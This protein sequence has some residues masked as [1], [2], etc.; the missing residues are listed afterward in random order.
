[1][2][3]IAPY[4]IYQ[5]FDDNGNPLALGKLNTYAAGTITPKA[6]YTD[7]GGLTQNSNPV[8]LDASGMANVWLGDGGYKFVLTDADDNVIFTVDNIGG[9]TDTAFGADVNT[10]TGNTNINTTYANSANIC[11]NSPTLSLLAATSAGEGFYI[12]VKNAGSGIVTIDP[13]GGELIDG[14]A[15]LAIPAGLSAL[16]I[17]NGTAWYSFFLATVTIAGNNAFTGNNSFSGDTTFTGEIY[18]PSDGTL[19]IATGSITPTGVYHLVDT[20]SAAASDDLDTIASP[21][22][23]QNLTLR[24]VSSARDVV[25]TNAGNIVTP[26]GT[27]ITLGTTNETISLLYDSTL[28]KW[29]VKASQ[30]LAATTSILGVVEKATQ[31]EV[32]A[33]TTEKYPDAALL[34]YHPGIA[35]FWVFC[36]VTAGAPAATASYNVSS[37]T[38]DGVGLFQVNFTTAF[39]SADYAVIGTGMDTTSSTNF[40]AVVLKQDDA[41]TT[42]NCPIQTLTT[43]T[44]VADIPQWYLVGYGDQ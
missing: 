26:T 7:A 32:E 14:A 17:T 1:M 11:T 29:I 8:E 31:A 3:T 21:T 37:I 41:R 24:T 43:D 10:I 38:D 15:T 28:V 5:A 9:T 4:G 18:T 19:T 2:A 16:I 22:N 23:G 44:T 20:E 12:T 35:K 33:E 42:S 30:P 27:S 36:T 25:I 6:T 39:A 40:G 34:K 13:D